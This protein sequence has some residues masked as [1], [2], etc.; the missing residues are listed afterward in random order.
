M[1]GKN[2]WLIQLHNHVQNTETA[3]Y[4]YAGQDMFWSED[5]NNFVCVVISEQMPSV[6]VTQFELVNVSATPTMETN[7][8]D[9]NKSGDLDS[10][11]AQLIWNMYNNQYEDFTDEVTGEKFVLADANHDGIL[12]TKDAIVIIDQ[13]KG[14]LNLG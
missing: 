12:D 5:H 9:V 4:K 1:N 13:I 7:N 11:D 8:W 10:S 6:D 3:T 2:M 14:T